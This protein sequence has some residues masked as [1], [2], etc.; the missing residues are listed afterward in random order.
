MR[1]DHIYHRFKDPGPAAAKLQKN[2]GGKRFPR[3]SSCG[4]D[5]VAKLDRC[6]GDT[7]ANLL[8]NLNLDANLT[9]SQ[10]RGLG[11]EGYSEPGFGHVVH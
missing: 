1:D 9:C 11:F 8:T 3:R 2:V 6:H 10:D 5:A 7:L 4:D